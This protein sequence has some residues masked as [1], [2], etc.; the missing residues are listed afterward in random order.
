[1]GQSVAKQMEKYAAQAIA[2]MR[3]PDYN[4][5]LPLSEAGV[6]LLEDVPSWEDEGGKNGIL[7][8][9]TMTSFF[10]E[11]DDPFVTIATLFGSY[12][13]EVIRRTCG[14]KCSRW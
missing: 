11:G 4:M 1:M 12:L 9:M 10:F 14:G 8:E 2:W 13:G 6:R 7:E 3:R 5:S